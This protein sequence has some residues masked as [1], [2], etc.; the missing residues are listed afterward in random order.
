MNIKTRWFIGFTAIGLLRG[1]I[2][3][4]YRNDYA[5]WIIPFVTPTVCALAAVAAW[6]IKNLSFPRA[7]LFGLMGILLSDV[8]GTIVYGAQTKWWYVTHDSETHAVLLLTLCIQVILFAVTCIILFPLIKLS[9][10]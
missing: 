4:D 7:I 6:S 10:K 8:T 5:L 2:F 9:K 3:P 1:F